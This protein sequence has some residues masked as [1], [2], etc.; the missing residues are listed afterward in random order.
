M[1]HLVSRDHFEAMLDHC[2]AMMASHL[3]YQYLPALCGRIRRAAGVQQH[4]VGPRR[5]VPG[6]VDAS[7]NRRKATCC[8][9]NNEN[10]LEEMNE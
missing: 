6:A 2:A 7:Q 1:W 5:P 10:E 9:V 8:R 4:C 3:G